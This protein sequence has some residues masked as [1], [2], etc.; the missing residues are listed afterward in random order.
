MSTVKNCLA[1]KPQRVIQVAPTDSVKLALELM[2]EHR[3]RAVLVTNSD[4]GLEGIVSQGDCAIRAFLEGR[5]AAQTT[6]AEIMTSQ[7]LT[8]KPGDPMELCMGLMATRGFRH[9]PVV[10]QGQVVGVVSIGDVVKQMMNEL[11]EHVSFLETYIKG[12]SA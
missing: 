11:G 10:A 1:S 3:V 12:H 8:V 9:L 5:D 2:K 4:G 7:P 6:A